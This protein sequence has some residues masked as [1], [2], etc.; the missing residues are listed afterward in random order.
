MYQE[1]TAMAKRS[2]ASRGASRP[3]SSDITSQQSPKLEELK[4]GVEALAALPELLKPYTVTGT[5]LRLPNEIGDKLRGRR[6]DAL[7]RVLD[8]VHYEGVRYEYQDESEPADTASERLNA[9]AGADDEDRHPPTD[10]EKL[11]RYIHDSAAEAL[12]ICEQ[13]DL[14]EQSHAAEKLPAIAKLADELVTAL[15]VLTEGSTESDD[16]KLRAATAIDASL[17]L[18]RA[19][20]NVIKLYR[21]DG[22]DALAGETD[23]GYKPLPE[24]EEALGAVETALNVESGTA[25]AAYSK[26]DDADDDDELS[27]RN[28]CDRMTTDET[29]LIYSIQGIANAIYKR[30]DGD[31]G[32]AMALKKLVDELAGKL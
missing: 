30:D 17:G 9:E 13:T 27:K 25:A 11:G 8:E 4:A 6:L 16:A 23:G 32:L 24:L 2:I 5:R 3:V 29:A 14:H 12:A 7:R 10:L 18:R 28:L 19:A 26:P 15:D 20:T 21:A 31:V 22:W 1:Y